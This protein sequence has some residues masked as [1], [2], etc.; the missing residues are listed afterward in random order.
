MKSLILAA[1]LITASAHAFTV[2]GYVWSKK[3]IAFSFDASVPDYAKPV[4]RAAFLSWSTAAFKNSVTFSE[5]VAPDIS[6]VFANN[7]SIG[8]STYLGATTVTQ[9]NGVI[10]SAIISINASLVSPTDLS[11]IQ[12]AALHE[13]GH[14]VGLNHSTEVSVMNPVDGILTLQRD[15]I[16]GIAS[17]YTIPLSDLKTFTA[18]LDK[19]GQQYGFVTNFKIPKTAI[20]FGSDG[21]Q[22]VSLGSDLYYFEAISE[23]Y[24]GILTKTKFILKN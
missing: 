14:A 22:V 8:G 7:I 17:T 16:D 12:H 11:T 24:T 13:I 5:S 20:P 23:I 6:V 21:F 10:Q 18:A 9:A 3:D 2:E 4:F 1:A 19:I 15:D